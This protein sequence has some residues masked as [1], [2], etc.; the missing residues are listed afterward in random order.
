MTGEAEDSPYV[1]VPPSPGEADARSLSGRR[2]PAT[3]LLVALNA[4]LILTLCLIGARWP[5]GTIMALFSAGFLIGISAV[6]QGLV[7][8]LEKR[9]KL[10]PVPRSI[11]Y[12][13]PVVLLVGLPLLG[14][15]PPQPANKRYPAESPGGNYT[16]RVDAPGEFWKVSIAGKDGSTFDETTDFLGHFNTYWCWD[17]SERLWLY[18]SDD[19]CVHYWE[20]RGPTWSHVELGH[21]GDLATSTTLNPPEALLPDYAR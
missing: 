16:A 1:P 13:S 18:N 15:T 14:V 21:S 7:A 10:G 5:L 9:I 11:A 12:L 2:R 3:W 17:D 6:W 20:R 4:V 19:G 8:L